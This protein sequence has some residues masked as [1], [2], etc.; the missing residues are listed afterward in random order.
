MERITTYKDAGVDTEK[1]AELVGDIAKLRSKTEGKR[2]LFQAFGLFAAGFDMSGYKEPVIF[3]ACDGVGTKIKLLLEY[4]L[5]EAAG[6]DLV[7]MN[8]NDILT[9]NA[10]P[11]MFLD[12]IGIAKLDEQ[13]ISRL[14]DG[15][16]DALAGCDCLLAGGETAEM[17]GLVEPGIVELSGFCV[18]A[19]EKSELLD[20]RT[21]EDGDIVLASPSQGF[22]ANG[23]SL[24]R[25]I[26]EQNADSFSD[27]DIVSLL[28]PTRIHYN[29]VMALRDAGI[30]VRA[31]AHITGGGIRENF[32]RILGER[33]AKLTLPAWENEPAQ[34]VLSFI[35]KDEAIH[36]FN[37]GVSWLMVVHPEDA[38][39][40]IEALD[41]SFAVGEIGGDGLEVEV[42]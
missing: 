4:D 10:L 2:Q 30:R 33:G 29:E 39:K 20:P 7:A 15:M 18:G 40:A 32:P 13:L 26:L 23:W 38:E 41:D 24:I 31:M 3:T 6:I 8:V 22:H 12:Y 42:L 35:E 25:K 37:M 9:A 16:T 27:E 11:L 28:A 34:K 19:A 36:A 17:P 21:I 14:I 1:A 5:P